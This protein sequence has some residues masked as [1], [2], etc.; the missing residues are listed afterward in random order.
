MLPEFVAIVSKLPS[1]F[2]L[3][4][5]IPLGWEMLATGSQVDVSNTVRFATCGCVA[6]LSR[7]SS[8]LPS[9]LAASCSVLINPL[10]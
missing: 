6:S 10:P 8:A 9:G 2:H 3:A 5:I 1:V 7:V 4:V